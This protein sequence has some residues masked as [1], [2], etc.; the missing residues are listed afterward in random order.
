MMTWPV[1]MALAV[2]CILPV[3]GTAFSQYVD[4]RENVAYQCAMLPELPAGALD[5]EDS[6]Q[7]ASVTSIPAG[8]LCT[9]SAIDGDTVSDQTGWP[10]TIAG[11]IAST[12]AGALTV[13][14]LR[15]RGQHGNLPTLAPGAVI[16]L[17]WAVILLSAHTAAV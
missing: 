1:T 2:L 16:A 13:I 9:F 3:A 12:L 15:V 4:G 6:L 10:S 17:I 5:S 14:A 11:M 7:E 8:R